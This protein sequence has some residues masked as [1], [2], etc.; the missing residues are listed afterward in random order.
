MKK[1]PYNH[2]KLFENWL[3]QVDKKHKIK[4]LN[5]KNS[6]WVISFIKD[7]KIGLNVS[8]HSRKGERSYTRLNH[9]RQKIIFMIKLLESRKISDITKLNAK[10]LHELFSDMRKGK[11]KTRF[12]TYYKSAGDYVKVFK[13]FWHWYQKVMRNKGKNIADI[14]EDLDTRG[15]KPAFVYFTKDDFDRIIK[16]TSYDLK[17]ILALAFDGGIRVTELINIKV[18]DFSNDFKELNIREETSKTFGRKIKLM[19]CSEQIK[20]YV[21]KMELKS[22]DYVCRKNPPMINKELRKLGKSLLTPEQIKSKN[23]SLYDFRHSS[24][25]FWLPRYKS[26]SAL[27]YRF[28]WKKS[29]MIYYYTELLGMKDTINEEDMYADVTKTE[30]EKEIA[31]LK[32]DF[33]K[34]AIITKISWEAASKNKDV[35]AELKRVAKRM[36]LKDELVYPLIDDKS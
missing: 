15:E 17:P 14:T 4:E 21:E 26:E 7:F 29:D 10:D 34:L 36:I 27:K 20:S 31:K 28:G 5:D 3:Q 9:L 35:K 19:L 12:G 30:L 25:C 1:D 32:K 22:N 8:R 18:S 6:A 13:T 2:Q 23:L 11:I 33:K 24:A 16:K